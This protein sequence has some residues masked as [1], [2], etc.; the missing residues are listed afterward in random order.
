MSDPERTKSLIAVA[1]M[2]GD[3]LGTLDGTQQSAWLSVVR[4]GSD[5]MGSAHGE[6]LAHARQVDYI[7]REGFGFDRRLPRPATEPEWQSLVA[8]LSPRLE[9]VT[10]CLL[11]VPTIDAGTLAR[12]MAVECAR[13][14]ATEPQAAVFSHAVRQSLIFAQAVV[15]AAHEAAEQTDV[16]RVTLLDVE[17]ATPGGPV[18]KTMHNWRAKSAVKPQ[19]HGTVGRQDSYDYRELLLW[20]REHDS[21]ASFPSEAEMKDWLASRR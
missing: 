15:A 13:A 5:V 2:L 16:I 6:A 20:L 7:L 9:H 4:A 10:A 11:Q 1:F 8:S 14:V 19:K 3:E 17:Q 18:V 21:D 12:R